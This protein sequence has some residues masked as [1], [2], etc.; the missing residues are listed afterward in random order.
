MAKVAAPRCS[1]SLTASP[2]LDSVSFSLNSG[3]FSLSLSLARQRRR[4][5]SK[6][7][8]SLLILCLS[9]FVSS[10]RLNPKALN[11]FLDFMDR[12][13]SRQGEGEAVDRRRVDISLF[14]L[15]L[16][17][18]ATGG[19]AGNRCRGCHAK[20]E[21]K[22]VPEDVEWVRF[23]FIFLV[24]MLHRKPRLIS[25]F[26][27]DTVDEGATYRRFCNPNDDATSGASSFAGDVLDKGMGTRS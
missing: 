5:R 16:L 26:F 11:V 21:A 2:S 19:A 14:S 23:R 4:Y 7:T 18:C 27:F 13:R 9:F 17:H 24:A 10:F 6:A 22:G 15:L 3:S 12:P 1:G 25:S 20:D 8:G